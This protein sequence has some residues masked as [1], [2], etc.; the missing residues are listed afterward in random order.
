SN[1]IVVYDINLG[2]IQTWDPIT[3]IFGPPPPHGAL[4]YGLGPNGPSTSATRLYFTQIK[5]FGSNIPGSAEVTNYAASSVAPLVRLTIPNHG[6]FNGEF[7]IVNF[8]GTVADWGWRV[9]VIDAN[10]VDLRDSTFSGTAGPV[11]GAFVL[12]DR[13]FSYPLN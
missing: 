13:N 5:N 8:T 9:N 10:T 11:N 12:Q 1:L 3:A 6:L 2:E 7:I 4:P